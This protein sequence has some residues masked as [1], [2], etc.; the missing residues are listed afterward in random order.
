MD[1]TGTG[2]KS[3]NVLAQIELYGWYGAQTRNDVSVLENNKIL[4]PEVLGHQT[5]INFFVPSPRNGMDIP[6]TGDET[7]CFVNMDEFQFHYKVDA[8]GHIDYLFNQDFQNDSQSIKLQNIAVS[9]SSGVIE[10]KAFTSYFDRSLQYHVGGHL[11]LVY[12]KN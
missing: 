4:E 3:N 6:A 5:Q 11:S 7:R 12:V 2:I 1:L 8:S 9:C 10:I